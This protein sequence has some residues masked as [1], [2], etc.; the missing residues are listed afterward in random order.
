MDQT[1]TVDRAPD[2][3]LTVGEARKV[4]PMSLPW[5]ALRRRDRNGPPF[6]RVGSRVFYP[7]SGLIAWTKQ[8]AA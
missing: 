4:L 2:R 8:Q 3:F 5:Y 6:V 7:E 1:P